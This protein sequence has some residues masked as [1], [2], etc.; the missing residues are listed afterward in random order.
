MTEF[1]LCRHDLHDL[2]HTLNVTP[3]TRRRRRRRSEGDGAAH[4]S[5][6]V[7]THT[8]HTRKHM[9]CVTPVVHRF[10][11]RLPVF[12]YFMRLFSSCNARVCDPAYF[13]QHATR[14]KD[15][16]TTQR[17]RSRQIRVP[18]GLGR[19]P[20]CGRRDSSLCPEYTHCLSHARTHNLGV[21]GDR[22]A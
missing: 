3:N 17:D 19:F 12:Q 14:H 15:A 13:M 1:M 18:Q 8:K 7:G 9:F 20:Q 6:S 11:D 2:C 21:D 5:D 16:T 10:S 4:K 22:A